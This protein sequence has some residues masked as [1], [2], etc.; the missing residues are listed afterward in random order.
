[1][2]LVLTVVGL[3]SSSWL[4]WLCVA[5][6]LFCA[7]S[8]ALFLRRRFAHL[9]SR[10]RSPW[11]LAKCVP[12]V[13]SIVAAGWLVGGANDLG[14]LGYGPHFSFYA[15]LHGNVLGWLLVG[16]FAILADP[17]RR[18]GRV[19]LAVIAVCF[20]SFFL[21]AFGIDQLRWLK[22][23]G[24]AGLTI[25]IPVGQV[26]FVRGARNAKARVL[27]MLSLLIFIGTMTLAWLNEAAML[28]TMQIAEVRVMVSLHGILNAAVVAPSF[29]AAVLLDTPAHDVE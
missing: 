18:F 14:I 6:P 15:A 2:A 21:I 7:G 13:F 9:R 25:A 29:L 16:A 12:F 8:F 1:M 24:V 17:E 4:S 11:E 26:C 3:F 20:V 19:H 27:G 23:I 10:L 5:W 28:G 22:P